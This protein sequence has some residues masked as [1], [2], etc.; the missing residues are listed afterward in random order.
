MAGGQLVNRFGR[1]RLAV[2]ALGF[3]VVLIAILIYMPSLWIALPI[4]FLHTWLR[5]VGFTAVYSLTLEQVPQARGTMMPLGG[6]FA[7]LGSVIGIIIGGAV[8]DLY[9]FLVLVPILGAFGVASV[10]STYFFVKDPYKK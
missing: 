1:K 6:M 10:I 5:G 2:S 3:A 8:L 9:G 4:D 7:S